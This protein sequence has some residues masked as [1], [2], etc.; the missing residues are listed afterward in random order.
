M[1]DTFRVI[2]T[3]TAKELRDAG[4]SRWLLGFAATF[5]LVALG[6]SLTQA[7]G[8]GQQGFTKTTAGLVNLCLLLV[9]LVALVLGA[10]AIV[11]ERERGTLASLL[12]QPVSPLEL[13]AGKFVGLTLAIWAAVALGFGV[14]GLA[15]ALIYPVA[16]IGG[17]VEF[18]LLSAGLAMTMLAIGL[19]ISVASDGRMKALGIALVLWFVLVLFYDLAAIG[20]AM[21]VSAS[22]R[23][24]LLA[25]LVNPVEGARILAIIGLQPD[26]RILGPLGAYL[27]NE[28]GVATTI[29]LLVG[30]LIAWTAVPLFIAGRVFANQDY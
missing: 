24:L 2:S 15:I 7:G 4:K 11:S 14:A 13:L 22:G 3:L 20:A 29:V 19:L 10:S 12:A 9:P 16:G 28:V 30:E 8:G 6:L 23:T 26:L 5:A 1:T 18:V 27:V 25:V 21:A 17:Y